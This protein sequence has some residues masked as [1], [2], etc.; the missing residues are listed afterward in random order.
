MGGGLSKFH[1]ASVRLGLVP[2]AC[3]NDANGPNGK[4]CNNGR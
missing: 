3:F 4:G 2:T 1:E